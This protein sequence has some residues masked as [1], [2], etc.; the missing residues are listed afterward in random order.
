MDEHTWMLLLRLAHVVC[1]TFW[2]GAMA[3]LAWFLIPAAMKWGPQGG[4]M[5]RRVAVEQR[6]STWGL[7]AAAVTIVS[8]GIMYGKLAGMGG[9]AWMSSRPGMAFAAGAVA[10]LVGLSLRFLF[11][12]PTQRKMAAVGAEMQAAGGP[13]PPALVERMAALGRRS[14][15]IASASAA[16]LVFAA[17]AMGVARY[18]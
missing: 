16:L 12:I 4:E 5:L 17:A 8:G 7:S 14:A 3:T 10:S 9:A 2:V 18:L 13:P 1:G 15:R 6:L 11:G